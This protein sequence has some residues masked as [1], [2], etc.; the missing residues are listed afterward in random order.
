MK[1]VC[2]PE[3]FK[4]N[5]SHQLFDYKIPFV[6]SQRKNTNSKGDFELKNRFETFVFWYTKIWAY[7]N[8]LQG[9]ILKDHST[10]RK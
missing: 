9:K 6:N 1:I 4:T 10:Y 3:S 7:L 2:I 8:L 5:I